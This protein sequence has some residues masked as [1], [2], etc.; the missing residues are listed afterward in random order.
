MIEKF[1][2]LLQ[3]EP[4][5]FS[6]LTISLGLF[7]ALSLFLYIFGGQIL[8]WAKFGEWRPEPLS[9]WFEFLGA[10]LDFIY[11]PTDWF[12]LTAVA[13]WLLDL[14]ASIFV[15]LIWFLTCL[16]LAAVLFDHRDA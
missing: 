5:L 16:G 4:A 12:G 14:P 2:G 9:E 3:R 10:D 1:K 8:S 6:N 7:G 13:A 11:S 15:P